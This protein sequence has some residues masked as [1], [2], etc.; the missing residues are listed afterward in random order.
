MTLYEHAV[1]ILSVHNCLSVRLLLLVN[2]LRLCTYREHCD[3]IGKESE[4][5]VVE[6]IL[7]VNIHWSQ[8]L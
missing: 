8:C 2:W 5:L 3:F 6:V 7:E 1:K 4:V